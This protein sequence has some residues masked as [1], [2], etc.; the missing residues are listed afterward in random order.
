VRVHALHIPAYGEPEALQWTP[1][2]PPRAGAGQVVI[3]V[4]AAGVN[5]P[6]LLVV[7]GL[8]QNL[9]P[10]PF[11]PGKEVAGIVTEAGAGVTEFRVGARVLAY[12]ENG[13]YAERIAVRAADCCALPAGLD[14]ADAIGLGLA[15]Q[16]AHFALF[17]RGGLQ[18]GETV[19]V[20]GA[21][22]GV[23]AAAVQLAKAHGARVIAAIGTPAK[24]AFAREQ[25]ADTVLVLD[26]A[27]PGR[28]REAVRDATAGRGAELAIDNLG[29]PV[30][31]AALRSLARSG[32]IVVVGF[33]GGPPAT[34][35]TNYLLIKNLVAAGLHWSD[36]RDEQPALVRRVQESIFALGQAR[37]LHAPITDALPLRDAALAL[38]RLAQRRALGKFVLLTEHYD[39]R[40]PARTPGGE[41]P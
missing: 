29:S 34:L 9:A 41:S 31:E 33:A 24:A 2:A 27:N 8:Y 13:G 17:E 18:P 39:G 23:G 21:T 15:F 10:L 16:T 1:I 22:G 32:R 35:A 7:R 28:L 20:T 14:A 26:P 30:F 25:G 37:R 19:L 6:D 5:Y 4:H 40:L 38:R 12:V 3:D 36:Y 11:A